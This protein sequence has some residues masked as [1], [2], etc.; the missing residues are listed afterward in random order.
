MTD[1]IYLF[2]CRSTFTLF[3]LQSWDIIVVKAHAD[4]SSGWQTQQG[5]NNTV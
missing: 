3:M 5:G 4:E 1:Y 2:D